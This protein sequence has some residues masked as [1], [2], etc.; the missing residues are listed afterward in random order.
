[1]INMVRLELV[2]VP[3][4]STPWALVVSIALFGRVYPS[5]G[6]QTPDCR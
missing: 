2:L 3:S 5:A 4:F 1:L 6:I